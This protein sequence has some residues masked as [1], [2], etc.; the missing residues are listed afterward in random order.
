MKIKCND[1]I[2]N[3]DDMTIEEMADAII[4]Y[5]KQIGMQDT[6]ERLLLLP[7]HEIIAQYN[8]YSNLFNIGNSKEF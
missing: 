3:A 7:E 6:K 2:N 4:K 5:K 1:N 8:H